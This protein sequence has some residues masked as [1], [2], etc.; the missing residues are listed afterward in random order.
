MIKSISAGAFPWA[1]SKNSR[2]DELYLVVMQWPTSLSNLERSS[3]NQKSSVKI[4]VLTSSVVTLA[5]LSDLKKSGSSLSNFVRFDVKIVVLKTSS[6]PETKVER[7]DNN[8]V[9]N[10]L[11]SSD[12]LCDLEVA[13]FPSQILELGLLN[14]SC[15][16]LELLLI[17]LDVVRI[18]HDSLAALFDFFAW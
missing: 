17:D 7:I 9:S 11:L 4:L 18:S 10:D 14:L 12:I 3:T 2:K 8:N 13:L 6:R 5:S 1:E 16:L 15:E